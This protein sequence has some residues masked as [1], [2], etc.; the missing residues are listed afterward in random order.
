MDSGHPASSHL[1]LP[2]GGRTCLAPTHSFT[3]YTHNTTCEQANLILDP[4]PNRQD[5]MDPNRLWNPSNPLIQESKCRWKCA[6]LTMGLHKQGPPVSAAKG[7]L[8]RASKV[9]FPT[10][11]TSYLPCHE[12]KT[13]SPELSLQLGLQSPSLA[14]PHSLCVPE[15]EQGQD[16]SSYHPQQMPCNTLTCH[17]LPL[18]GLLT[19]GLSNGPDI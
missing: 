2:G 14:W 10:S 13:H 18:P 12:S 9:P 7:A 4:D 3:L 16:R 6:F 17:H 15:E 5:L 1:Q 8:A 19:A 11:D